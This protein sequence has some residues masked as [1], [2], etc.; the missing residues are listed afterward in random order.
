MAMMKRRA[1]PRRHGRP[2]VPIERHPQ[3]FEI[4]CIW[5]FLGFGLGPFDAT[6]RALMV[7]R[8][9]S[10]SMADIEGVL[11]LS[12]MSVPLPEAK[13]EP[14]AAE[15]RLFATAKRQRPEPW[16]VECSAFIQGLIIFTGPPVNVTGSCLC[17]DHLLL[18]GWR[19]VLAGLAERIET[20]L[21]SNIPPADLAAL[22]PQARKLVE[23][24]TGAKFPKRRHRKK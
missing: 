4:A 3:R 22:G 1:K 24:L 20:T 19:P 14:N 16:L 12:Q 10:I 21:K 5:A 15:R 6:N 7:V 18:R 11:R 13:D 23:R 9:G 8:G 2:P 17:L